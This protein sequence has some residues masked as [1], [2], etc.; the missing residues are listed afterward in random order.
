MLGQSDCILLQEN[1]VWIELLWVEGRKDLSAL[2]VFTN[3][4]CASLYP[5]GILQVFPTFH[6]LAS[7]PRNMNTVKE[8]LRWA[9]CSRCQ[10]CYNSGERLSSTPLQSKGRRTFRHRGEREYKCFGTLEG[11]SFNTII[12]PACANWHLS[13]L[14]S[15]LPPHGYWSRAVLDGYISK[16][17]IPRSS[18][19]TFWVVK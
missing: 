13:E 17:I 16:G 1:E 7:S 11:R 3:H 10:D 5:I 2:P 19:R 6:L 18:K 15:S 8:R 14:G 9:Y 12:P 4:V